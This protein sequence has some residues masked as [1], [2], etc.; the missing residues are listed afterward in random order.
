MFFIAPI[1]IPRLEF[2]TGCDYNREVRREYW[3]RKGKFFFHPWKDTFTFFF[4]VTKNND[5]HF[6][7]SVLIIESW[8][9]AAYKIRLNRTLQKLLCFIFERTNRKDPK[10][11][12]EI[13]LIYRNMLSLLFPIGSFSP[14]IYRESSAYSTNAR[15]RSTLRGVFDLRVPR[16]EDCVK[17]ERNWRGVDDDSVEDILI[18]GFAYYS[19]HSSV[20][21]GQRW[22]RE[23]RAIDHQ[24]KG[25]L[26]VDSFPTKLFL[27]F[28]LF[29]ST[30]SSKL[31]L[32]AHFHRSSACRLRSASQFRFFPCCREIDKRTSVAVDFNS[33]P[34]LQNQLSRSSIRRLVFNWPACF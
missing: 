13:F 2:S 15:P 16:N 22:L 1:Q 28:S 30:A 4:S 24:G 19:R 21:R 10:F 23:F 29:P 20:A 11:R 27:S 26:R 14:T 6:L 32:Y 5:Y 9:N 33:N 8:K 3:L 7:K 18:A 12:K 34:F 17:V 31:P 25:R